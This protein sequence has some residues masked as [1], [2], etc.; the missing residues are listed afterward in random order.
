MSKL[1]VRS[2]LEKYPETIKEY[3]LIVTQIRDLFLKKQGDYGPN[4]ISMGGDLD[5]AKIAIVIRINDKV[6]RLLNLLKNDST[7]NNEPIED[8]FMDLANY[9]IMA[10]IVKN[11]KWGK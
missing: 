11:G 4:N 10:T 5:L 6:Q 2:V 9:G 1:Q 8:S 7:P 3:D